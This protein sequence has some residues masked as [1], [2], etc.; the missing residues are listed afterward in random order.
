MMSFIDFIL[1][2]AGLTAAV[3][4]AMQSPARNRV[5][6][7]AAAGLTVWLL[8][9]VASPANAAAV[10]SAVLS[11]EQATLNETLRE[12][13]QGNQYQGIE[14]TQPQGSLSDRKITRRVR[15]ELPEDVKLSVSN[16][17]V[18][19]SGE[20][21]DLEFAKRVIEDIKTI[22]GVHEVSYDLGLAS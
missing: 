19:L 15:K 13:P 18:R 1:V 21:P 4:V 8:G 22:P 20:M 3:W 6:I 16:G 2:T 17:S 11:E 14:Y 7:V 12:T 9:G 5:G 10:D